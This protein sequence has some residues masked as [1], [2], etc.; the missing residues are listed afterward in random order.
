METPSQKY[1]NKLGL[2]DTEEKEVPPSSDRRSFLKKAGLGGLALGAFIR[3][4]FA[5]TLEHVMQ[6]VNKSSAPTDLKITDM[7]YAVVMNGNA[8]CPIIRIDTNQGIS[9]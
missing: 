1:L 2:S 5:P 7:R 8:R 3:Q 4:P 9:G 6:K